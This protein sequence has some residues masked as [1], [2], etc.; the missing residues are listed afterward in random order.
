M[1]LSRRIRDK[2]SIETDLLRLR[3]VHGRTLAPLAP[4]AKPDGPVA[5]FV[6]LSHF[7]YHLK[8]EGMLA[9]ALELRDYTPAVLVPSDAPLAERYLRAFGVRRFVRISDYVDAGMEE[10][11]KE[12]ARGLLSGSASMSDLAGL[13][14]R[15][16]SIGRYIV[17]TASRLLYEG[18]IDLS[19]ER[20]R[21]M[22][23]DLLLT[24]VRSTLAAERLLDELK[25]EVVIFNERNYAAEAPLSDL[26]LERGLDVIQ[27]VSAARDD[28]LVF[29]RYTHETRRFHPRSLSDA[30]W[31]RVRTLPWTSARDAE[32]EA[33]TRGR[34]DKANA[35]ARRRLEWTQERSVAEIREQVGLDASKKTAVIY[36]H[37][38][39]DANMF[40]GED[41][42]D[43][44]EEWF[45]DTVRAACANPNVNW[46][47]KLHP[48][49]VWKRKR[50]QAEGE[51]DDLVVIRKRIGELPDH[52]KLLRPETPIGTRSLF[53][54][55]DYGVTIRGSVGIELPCFGIP[56][57]TAG[58]G[59]YSGLGFTIDSATREE[60]L[61]RLAHIEDVPRLSP[62]QIELAR[63]HAYALFCL[64]PTKFTSFSTRISPLEK[65]GR[66]LDHNLF[67]NLR[68]GA[69]LRRAADLRRFADWVVDS[70]D[71]DYLDLT[72]PG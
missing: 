9:K 59:F 48:D 38:L 32:L 3:L 68:S 51:L 8:L 44:Q 36:S 6:S 24:A 69:E 62:E 64:R 58:T 55:T 29:K 17:S 13:T 46:I 60:Y 19:E 12:T 25:P 40:Y 37:I 41:L 14:F 39:W 16:A 65:M 18:R 70:R 21:A 61:D 30:S 43:D 71:L 23:E 5:L 42:F 34:Y 47:V 50:E 27:F 28:S 20:T 1:S 56:V 35:M 10:E 22:I 4:L 49:N 66:P 11:A 53:D 52:V 26:A 63:R 2:L 31:E 72:A 57:L 45:V 54:V 7:I 33:E 67:V 15:G